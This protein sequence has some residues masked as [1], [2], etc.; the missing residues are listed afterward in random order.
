MKEE[1]LKKGIDMCKRNI[2]MRI[3]I[4]KGIAVGIPRPKEWKLPPMYEAII[5]IDI[6]GEDPNFTT[7]S[8]KITDI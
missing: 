3:I 6:D 5:P 2:L 1:A 4:R 8:C 7:L